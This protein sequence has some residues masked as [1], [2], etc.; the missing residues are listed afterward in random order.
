VDSEVLEELMDRFA[1]L[2]KQDAFKVHSF[3][4]GQ[5]VTDIPGFNAKVSKSLVTSSLI[6]SFVCQR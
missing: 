1:V 6:F 3:L 4:E 2:L 5:S